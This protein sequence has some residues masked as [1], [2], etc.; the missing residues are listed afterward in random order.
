MQLA[1]AM[2]EPA[3]A[4]AGLGLPDDPQAPNATTQL[5]DA[6]AIVGRLGMDVGVAN[7]G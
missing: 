3:A 1:K 2:G 5:K 6:S 7:A 4:A